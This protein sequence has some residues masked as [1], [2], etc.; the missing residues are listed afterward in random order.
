MRKYQ[1][2]IEF[3]NKSIKIDHNYEDEFKK[4][5][6]NLYYLIKHQE[7]IEFHN[8]AIKIDHNYEDESN[9]KGVI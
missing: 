5:R 7:T 1:V 6:Y 4:K 3:H 9:K 8:K 2:T